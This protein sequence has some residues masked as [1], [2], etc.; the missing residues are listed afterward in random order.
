MKSTQVRSLFAEINVL[1]ICDSSASKKN[2]TLHTP[3]NAIC[4]QNFHFSV[5]V[6]HFHKKIKL[7]SALI[8][9][10]QKILSF[11][12]ISHHLK[13]RMEIKAK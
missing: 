11:N 4:A 2:T 8:H 6:Y 9:L 10:I 5:L 13:I 3:Q 7:P 12:F 1:S